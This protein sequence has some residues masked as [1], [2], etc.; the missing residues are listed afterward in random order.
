MICLRTEGP[1]GSGLQV[2]KRGRDETIH[3]SKG[4]HSAPPSSVSVLVSQFSSD[5]SLY[6][7]NSKDHRFGNVSTAQIDVG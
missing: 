4:K 7:S 1:Y 6:E 2:K 5:C 3:E